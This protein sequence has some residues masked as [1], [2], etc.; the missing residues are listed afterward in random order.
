MF[1]DSSGAPKILQNH[2]LFFLSFNFFFDRLFLSFNY[3]FEMFFFFGGKLL[4]RDVI[5]ASQTLTQ[6]CVK[7]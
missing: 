5:R 6:L 4:V 7:I 3:L 1:I 2:N